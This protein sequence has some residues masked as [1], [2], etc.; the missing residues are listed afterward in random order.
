MGKVLVMEF[1]SRYG[2][3]N[4]SD[5]FG[6]TEIEHLDLPRVGQNDVLRLEIAMN[7]AHFM[8]AIECSRH[9]D[10]ELDS[11][12]DGYGRGMLALVHPCT[13]RSSFEVFEH[14]VRMTVDFVD[15]V[16]DHDSVVFAARGGSRFGQ[17][18]LRQISRVREEQ[19]DGAEP[20]ELRITRQ[21]HAAHA[22]L[23]DLANDFVMLD[24]A[25]GGERNGIDG[26]C[27]AAEVG[28]RQR[29]G[30]RQAVGHGPRTVV[31]FTS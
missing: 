21:K 15:F 14:H 13:E 23:A 4:A 28:R 19:L 22:A 25:A 26:S 18:S 12:A 29:N 7:D 11:N 1:P 31:Q 30:Q 2:L 8:R 6:N 24:D 16:K 3:V 20:R 9:G 5:P 27:V 10:H 17:E